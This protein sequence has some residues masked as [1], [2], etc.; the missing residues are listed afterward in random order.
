MVAPF[1][2]VFHQLINQH[3]TVWFHLDNDVLIAG[4]IILLMTVAVVGTTLWSVQDIGAR[5]GRQ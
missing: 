2:R 5:F 4:I 3:Q 1:Q